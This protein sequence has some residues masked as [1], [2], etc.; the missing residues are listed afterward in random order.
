MG[1]FDGY[2]E[3]DVGFPYVNPTYVLVRSPQRDFFE[4]NWYHRSYFIINNSQKT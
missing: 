3:L 4:V 2:C 1:Y